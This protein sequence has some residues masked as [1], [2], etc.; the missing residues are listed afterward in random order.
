MKLLIVFLMLTG[1]CFAQE[2]TLEERVSN[3]E[4]KVLDM[5]SYVENNCELVLDYSGS[6]MSNCFDGVMSGVRTTL[7]RIGNSI[8]VN[9]YLECKRYRL[10]CR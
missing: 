1:S 8:Y 2:L 5:G 9:N 10:I 6:G 7:N 4:S 3:L